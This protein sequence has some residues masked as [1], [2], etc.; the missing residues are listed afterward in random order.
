MSATR[1]GYDRGVPTKS[2][3]VKRYIRAVRHMHA[4]AA[5]AELTNAARVLALGKL[6]GAQLAEAR[7]ILAAED[8]L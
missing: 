4:L 5:A 7:V 8:L 3:H 6:T 1:I 2:L